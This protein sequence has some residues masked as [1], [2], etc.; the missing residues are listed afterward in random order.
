MA[1]RIYTQILSL[2]LAFAGGVTLGLVYDLLRPIRRRG[3]DLIW[4]LL[5]CIAAAAL[6][7]VF[8]MRSETGTLGTMDLAASLLA[9]LLYFHLLSP[10]LFPIFEKFVLILGVFFSK[11]QVLLKKVP[12]A[13]KKVFQNLQG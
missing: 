5:F 6:C 4:D 8:A 2:L 10:V 11:A 7:F 1:L 12:L 3:T 9:L 13:A